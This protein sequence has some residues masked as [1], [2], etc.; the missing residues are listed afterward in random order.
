MIR[1]RYE[2]LTLVLTVKAASSRDILSVV[3]H[4]RVSVRWDVIHFRSLNLL[5]LI[6]KLLIQL[7]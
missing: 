5:T 7:N 2:L 3:T 6:F 4:V 1:Q